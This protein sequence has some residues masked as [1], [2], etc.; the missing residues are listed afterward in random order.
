[1]DYDLRIK[2]KSHFSV[3]KTDIE[4]NT[5]KNNWLKEEYLQIKKTNLKYVPKVFNINKNNLINQASDFKP[6]IKLFNRIKYKNL[7]F[8]N[9]NFSVKNSC[10]FNDYQKEIINYETNFIQNRTYKS[11]IK[12]KI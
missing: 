2:K 5:P 9:D 6:N 4:I 12:T 1:M 3:I 7:N 8:I 11:I 10:L